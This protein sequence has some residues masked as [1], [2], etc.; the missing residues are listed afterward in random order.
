M[1]DGIPSLDEIRAA[2]DPVS[3]HLK[4]TPLHPYPGLSKLLGAEVWVKHENH[5]ATGAF[6]VRGGVHLAS[7]LSERERAAGLVTAS[8]GNHGQSIAF[9][10]KVTGT[11]VTVAV[12]E[13][14]NP[15]KVEAMRALGARVVHHGADFDAAREWIAGEAARRGARFVGPTDAELIAGVGTYALE[16]LEDLPEVEVI[17]VPVGAGSGACGVC[18]VAKQLSPGVEV[19]GVQSESAPAVQRSWRSGRLEEAPMRTRAEGLA[20]RV[21][22]ESAMRIL[23]HPAHGLD[24]FLLVSDQALERAIWLLLEHTHNMAE[25]AGA[26]A[27]A[28]ALSVRERLAGRKVVLILSGGNLSTTALAEIAAKQSGVIRAR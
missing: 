28:G 10:G 1:S 25:H 13:V 14:A 17:F 15:E 27:L 24:D 3:V 26:A 8:T 12:P 20:T 7:R 6:K 4:R 16:I 2:R 18:L 19:I 11:A 22:H 23:G 21:A 5:L 9:A